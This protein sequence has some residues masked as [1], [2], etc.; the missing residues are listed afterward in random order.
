MSIACVRYAPMSVQAGAMA[1]ST[2]ALDEGIVTPEAVLLELPAAGV[3]SRLLAGLVDA[4]VLAGG[5]ILALT[6]MVPLLGDD[7]SGFAIAVAVTLFVALLVYPVV[8]QLVMR[9]RTVGK[10]ALGLRAVTTEGAPI[11][12]R[13]AVLRTMGGLVDHL[14]PPGGIAGVLFVLGT[15]RSQSVGDLFA[16]TIVIREPPRYIVPTAWWFPVPPGYGPY[17]EAI[18]P[19]PLTDAHYGLVREFLLRTGTL[20]PAA[21]AALGAQ[22]ADSIAEVLRVRRDP[23]V[24]PEAYLLCVVSRY[25]QRNFTARR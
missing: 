14:I 23:R 2:T 13:H 4:S 11:Q 5:W 18:D 6:I 21:R 25:Q 8:I 17:A 12:L 9:G 20:A 16:G 22:L 10:A 24:H 7:G 15:R 1:P 19:S 3:G